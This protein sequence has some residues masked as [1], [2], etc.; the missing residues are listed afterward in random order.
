MTDL[1]LPA[2]TLINSYLFQDPT[3][4]KPLDLWVFFFN[5]GVAILATQFWMIVALCLIVS[6]LMTYAMWQRGQLQAY[7]TVEAS[8]NDQAAPDSWQHGLVQPVRDFFS[9]MR[10]RLLDATCCCS[11]SCP[12][13]QTADPEIAQAI[14]LQDMAQVQPPAIASLDWP[15][16]DP[17]MTAQAALDQSRRVESNLASAAASPD[18]AL[19]SPMTIPA[20][21]PQLTSVTVTMPRN[22]SLRRMKE[23]DA[24]DKAQIQTWMNETAQLLAKIQ[25]L[26]ASRRE[27]LPPA[28]SYHSLYENEDGDSSL[29]FGLSEATGWHYKSPPPRPG[30]PSLPPLPPPPVRT[31]SLRL[32]GVAKTLANQKKASK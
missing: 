12:T 6:G 19:G 15:P 31:S 18:Q 20:P 14:P 24:R 25:T 3:T 1:L 7:S 27:V 29:T 5:S 28:A 8:Q 30:N 32:K 17:S 13:C 16:T 4:Y 22:N 9:R 2:S 11:C 21:G 26:N 10:M 23:E